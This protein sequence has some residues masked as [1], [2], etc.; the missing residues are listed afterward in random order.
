[1]TFYLKDP[2][3]RVDYALNWGANYLDGQ[4]IVGSGWTVEPEEL[5]GVAVLDESYDLLR[6]AARLGGGVAGRVYSV[7]N[8]VAL[9]D[10]TLD[11]RSIH[12]RVEER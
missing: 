10:G 12:V 8:Q 2:L 9:S 4:T 11:R 3:S 1:M 6:S 5:G 7:S